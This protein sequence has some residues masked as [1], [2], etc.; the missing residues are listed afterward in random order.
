MSEL[1]QYLETVGEADP[2]NKIYITTKKLDYL[3]T[4]IFFFVLSQV[5]RI[6]TLSVELLGTVCLLTFISAAPFL[7]AFISV[8]TAGV[9][10]G[11]GH[12]G[13]SQARTLMGEGPEMINPS[14]SPSL[15]LSQCLAPFSF[16]DWFRRTPWMAR[17]LCVAW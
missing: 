14:P 8:A 17:R 12:A 10:E 11:C 1:A 9:H 7:P 13:R 2:L 15:S 6:W 16:S 5:N 4:F 3:S